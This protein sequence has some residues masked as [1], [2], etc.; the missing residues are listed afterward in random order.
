MS[1]NSEYHE[2]LSFIFQ[3]YDVPPNIIKG[4]SK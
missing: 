3:S 2:G 4:V 1:K